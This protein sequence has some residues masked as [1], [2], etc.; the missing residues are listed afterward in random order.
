MHGKDDLM[1]LNLKRYLSLLL[2]LMLLIGIVPHAYAVEMTEPKSTEPEET[3]V[4]VDPT[5]PTEPTEPPN[6]A[7]V[8]AVMSLDAEDNGIM[9]LASTTSNVLLFD[10]A[11][12]NYTTVLSSQ[13]SVTYKPNGTD[14]SVTA[15]IKNLGWH[16][17]RI[18]GVSYPDDPIYCIEPCKNFAAST[19]GNYVDTDITVDGSG[20]SRGAN[21]WYALPAER[22]EAISLTLLYS[23]QLWD[24]SYS[25]TTTAMASNPNVSLRVATQFLIYEIVTGLRDASTFALNDS[26]GYCYYD[27]ERISVRMDDGNSLT[28]M[29]Y[30]MDQQKDFGYPCAS[31]YYTVAQG[32]LDCGLDTNVLEQAL[33]DSVQ[34]AEVRLR[35]EQQN[36]MRFF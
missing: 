35:K 17:A 5:E 10:Q 15:Y 26:N 3:V 36:G 13:V 11:S 12:P 8:P 21:V 33:A 7:D 25:V 34:Q 32:Y 27:K 14:A 19:S 1:I 29:V 22:R 30:I 18:N 31:Y 23:R 28:G 9:A 20:T 6:E 16:F 24:D 2:V 4:T